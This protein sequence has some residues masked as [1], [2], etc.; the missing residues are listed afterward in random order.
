MKL[1]AISLAAAIIACGTA[2]AAEM[3]IQEQFDPLGPT[4]LTTKTA[5]GKT[6][7]YVDDGKR[8]GK[9]VLFIG[10]SGT[11]AY[12]Y[13]LTGF[14]RR[15]S[16]QLGLR[17]IAVERDGYGVT[18]LTKGYTYSDYAGEAAEI[19]GKLR[20][21]KVSVVAISGGGPYA[22]AFLAAHPDR[23]VSA[24]FLAAYSQFDPANPDTSGLC[25]A[26]EAKRAGFGDIPLKFGH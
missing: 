7:G 23:I 1:K 16:D 26:P 10:G 18:G 21:D 20:V 12:A 8:D 24:H 9:P 19:L 4:V 14:L 25:Q 15:M 3:D 13:A 11:S 2:S 5:A 17:F 6:I 22:A